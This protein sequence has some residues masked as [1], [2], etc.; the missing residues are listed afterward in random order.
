MKNQFYGKL[1]SA[2]ML[3]LVVLAACVPASNRP[4]SQSTEVG[5]LA[6]EDCRLSMDGYSVEYPA[7]CGHLEVYEDRAAQ[8]GRKIMLRIAVIPSSSQDR[9]S[10]PLFLLAGGP[11][12]AAGEAFVPMLDALSRVNFKHDLVMVDQRGTG[13]S[14]EL[15]CPKPPENPDLLPGEEIPLEENLAELAR[16]QDALDGDTRFYTT[17]FATA[18]LEDAR[19]ALGYDQINLLGVSYGTRAALAYLQM[20]PEHVRTITLDSVVPPGWALGAFTAADAQKAFD[21]MAERCHADDPC[22]AAFPDISTAFDTLVQQLA[23]QPV[24]VT[25]PD[26]RS[27]ENRTVKLTRDTFVLTVRLMLYNSEMVALLPLVLHRAAQGD[28]QPMAAQ[29]LMVNQPFAESISD[30]MYLSVICA[31]DVPFYPPGEGEPGNFSFSFA[32][33]RAMCDSWSHGQQPAALRAAVHSDVPALLL[34]GSADPVTPP[35]NAAEVAEGLPNS[36]QIVLEGLG[37]NVLYRG[38]LP[39]IIADFIENKSVDQLALECTKKISPMP[40]FISLSGP[41]P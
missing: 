23:A 38:C 35:E 29:Y 16:C 36:R 3:L 17:E 11:G 31:E 14:N 30:G 40:F 32:E 34:S 21:R 24:E 1:L 27:G 33:M 5:T 4:G 9:A 39:K 10:D 15:R 28:W 25:L 20:Y 26:P 2:G 22:R 12:Q 8:S 6:L 13:Q 19:V 37:H 7:K 41:Q 18:D